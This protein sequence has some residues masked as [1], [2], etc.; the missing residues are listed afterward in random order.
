MNNPGKKRKGNINL[1]DFDESLLIGSISDMPQKAALAPAREP[2]PAET[3]T[4]AVAPA[5][6]EPA[7]ATPVT[8]T[9]GPPEA[10]PVMTAGVPVAAVSGPAVD[11]VPPAADNR[12]GEE[13]ALAVTSASAEAPAADAKGKDDKKARPVKTWEYNRFLTPTVGS[14]KSNI[15]ISEANHQKMKSI[16]SLL[17]RGVSITDY[18]ENMFQSHWEQYGPEIQRRLNEHSIFK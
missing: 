12:G 13:P 5:V 3:D 16:I 6:T 17:G 10:A 11:V 1:D 2:V 14:K 15:Y 8:A 4:P 18:V 7:V 9:P